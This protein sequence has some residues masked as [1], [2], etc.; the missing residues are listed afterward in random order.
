MALAMRAGFFIID[1][2]SVTLVGGICKQ[3]FV[4]D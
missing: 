4:Y 1:A 3:Y 2:A